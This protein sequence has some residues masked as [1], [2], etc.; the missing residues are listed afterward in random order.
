[1]K[2]HSIVVLKV[3]IPNEGLKAGT[4]GAIIAIRDTSYIVEFV[5]N[6]GTT[7]AV[8]ELDDKTLVSVREVTL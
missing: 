5:N 7:I 1:M 8:V 6:E 2:I 4:R 3:D